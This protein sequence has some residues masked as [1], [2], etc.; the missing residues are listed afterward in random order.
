[1]YV[2]KQVL[3]MIPDYSIFPVTEFHQKTDFLKSNI[4]DMILTS[5]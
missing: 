3:L 1:M 4:Q 5:K 2:W